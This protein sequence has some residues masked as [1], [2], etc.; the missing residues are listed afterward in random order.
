M[1]ELRDFVVKNKDK[2][3]QIYDREP[4]FFE[5]NLIAKT[6][7]EEPFTLQGHT[8]KALNALKDFLNENREVFDSFAERYNISK[9]SLLDVIFFSVFF[10]DLGKGTL[11]FYND[12]ILNKGKSYHPLYSI[13]FTHN[14]NLT[15]D[16]IDY[17]TLAILTHHTVLHDEIY[18]DEKFKDMDPPKFFKE[19]LKFA[20]TYP[21]YYKKFFKR[22]CPYTFRFQISSENPYNLLRSNFSWNFDENGILDSLNII[23]SESNTS[24]KK[25]IRE[26][27]GFITGNL[28][29]AD[30]LASGSYITTREF[31]STDEFWEKIRLRANDKK[32]KFV[33]KAFQEEAS[34]S[35]ENLLI[36][37]P[38]GEGKTEASL[39]WALN[40]VKNEHTKIIYTLPT[41][42]TS[43]SMYKRLKSYFGDENV[44]ILHGSSS[45][46][47]KEE[48]DDNE[49]IWKEKILN[50]T[51]SKPVTVSTLD[52]FVLSF[53]N[54]KKWPLSQLN[55][56]NCLLIIDEIHSYDWQMLGALKRILHELRVRGCKFTIMS[57]TFP[58]NIEKFLL[59]GIEYRM[60]TENDL[61]D[62]RPFTLKTEKSQ[63]ID[64]TDDIVRAFKEK[65]KVL[66][67]TN[68]VSKSKEVY[69]NLKESGVF[70]TSKSF[71]KST[72]L[73]LYNSQFTKEDRK[74]KENEIE[75]KEKWKDKGLVL[76]AT[77][78]VEISLDIDFDVLFTEIAPLDA[79]VQRA[80]RINRN[81][82]PLRMGEIYVAME[83]EAEN[84]RGDWSYPYERNVIECSKTMVKEGPPSLGEM[85]EM[86]SDLYRSLFEI[87]QIHFE[88]K[89]KFKKGYDKY[90][91]VI[92]KKGPYSVRFRTE[93]L[94]E[95][96]KLL[97]LRDIDDRFAKIDVVPAVLAGDEDA[98]RFE[99]TVGIPKYLFINMLKEGRIDEMKRFYLVHGCSYT[100][101]SGLDLEEEDD[102]N[103]I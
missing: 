61:F 50:K 84:K 94:E 101:E 34:R 8:E 29:R 28:I 85:A 26:I 102:W 37:I 87:E 99:N 97:A 76:V 103:F 67:V 47:L 30:W 35:R 70:N 11:E 21:E 22:E 73:I 79:L 5:K 40:N 66:V 64:K 44:G 25:R 52:A 68:T 83:I 74:G 18:S 1:V 59:E 45:I 20:E 88:F 56:E 63:I 13:Y 14:L 17:V 27:Y 89:N 96:S 43:N 72:N 91:T 41:Q 10:H 71:D 57:A 16:D 4:S 58:E 31:I 54:V 81:K 7:S 75:F 12:K 100:Y 92:E 90:C 51:F 9:Q 93:D 53:F 77:Q 19:T 39:L 65:K 62:Y 55:I 60:I 2:F 3:V 49:R 86:V 46:I 80:G 95:I 48:Y 23:L 33:K 38:T 15:I 69:R 98:D 82:D 6:G 36:K 24:E 78:V 42:V 32:R